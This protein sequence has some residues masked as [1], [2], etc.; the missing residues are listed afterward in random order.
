MVYFPTYLLK[1]KTWGGGLPWCLSPP[2]SSPPLP[3][4]PWAGP[5]GLACRVCLCCASR[6]SP[7]A[8]TT[9]VASSWVLVPVLLLCTLRL[10][11][12]L[13]CQSLSLAQLAFSLSLGIPSLSLP[14]AFALVISPAGVGNCT[15]LSLPILDSSLS[16]CFIIGS[17]AVAATCSIVC[18]WQTL[19][20]PTLLS[21]MMVP[22]SQR[23]DAPEGMAR[24]ESGQP[25]GSWLLHVRL[26]LAEETLGRC[27][28]FGSCSH[29]EQ[30]LQGIV[31]QRE[32]YP[33]PMKTIKLHCTEQEQG[34]RIWEEEKVVK[35]AIGTRVGNW[36]AE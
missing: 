35:L 7:L 29:W 5:I 24:P 2:L 14:W 30:G 16:L 32:I 17:S 18:L 6:L 27:A 8:T 4:A 3:C 1:L 23:P 15:G 19:Q 34:Q 11:R 26:S 31:R 25:R 13:F 10:I 21:G 28:V 22:A 33:A 36:L 12:S 9:A 20:F